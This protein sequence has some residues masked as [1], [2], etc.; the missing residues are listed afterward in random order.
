MG[1]LALVITAVSLIVAGL[2]LF[3]V[4][5]L[6]NSNSKLFTSRIDRTVGSLRLTNNV[7]Y[8]NSIGVHILGKAEPAEWIGVTIE[9]MKGGGTTVIPLTL[10]LKEALTL[11][12]LLADAAESA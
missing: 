10:S 11:S 9:S 8:V 3:G 5:Q 1:T 4:V 7:A 6:P 12:K 2:A